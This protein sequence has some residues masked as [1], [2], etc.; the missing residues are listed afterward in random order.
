[1]KVAMTGSSGMIGTALAASALT[2]NV[3]RVR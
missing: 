3:H 1:M 2:T